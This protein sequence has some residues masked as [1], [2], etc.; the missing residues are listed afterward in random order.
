V[1]DLVVVGAGPTGVEMAGQIA[2]L[3]RD[4]L[5]RDFR[6]ADPGS[7]RNLLVVAAEVALSEVV[8]RRGRPGL[9][10]GADRLRRVAPLLHG[11]RGQAVNVTAESAQRAP[12]CCDSD[13]GKP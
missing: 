12:A 8:E 4:T 1:A 3:A 7:G 5:R 6:A 10:A 11:H 2:E 13:G 9:Q